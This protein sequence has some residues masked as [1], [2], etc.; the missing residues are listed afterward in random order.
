MLVSADYFQVFGAT[1][2]VGRT[3]LAKDEAPGAAPVVVLSHA[4]WQDRFGGDRNILNR[5]VML[6]GESHQ[7]VGVLPAGSFDRETS[8]FW[9]P[10]LLRA[11]TANP[12]LSLAGRRSAG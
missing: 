11:R 4:V 2:A 1:T 8:G 12:R 6:D 3:F 5:A 7:V 10:L 9:K